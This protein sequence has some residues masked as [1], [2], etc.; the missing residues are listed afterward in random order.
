LLGTK[1][2]PAQ[3]GQR[4][5]VPALRREMPSNWLQYEQRNRIGIGLANPGSKNGMHAKTAT[6]FNIN[7][8]I[9]SSQLPF[10]STGNLTSQARLTK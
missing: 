7:Y 2:C 6:A 9:L 3:V 10:G 1:T 8:L 4:T 5:L